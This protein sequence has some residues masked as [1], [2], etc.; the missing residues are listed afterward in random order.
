VTPRIEVPVFLVANQALGG[1]FPIHSGIEVPVVVAKAQALSR[2]RRSGT[3]FKMLKGEFP[4]IGW[5]QKNSLPDLV[6]CML[7][8]TEQLLQTLFEW[9][10]VGT[11]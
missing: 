4:W 2:Q 9:R 7:P 3:L 5:K 11:K 10:D 8:F 1:N 6:G